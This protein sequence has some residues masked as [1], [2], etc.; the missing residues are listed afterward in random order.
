M[1]KYNDG[2]TRLMFRCVCLSERIN[3][4]HIG[5]I[6]VENADQKKKKEEKNTEEKT[7]AE[8]QGYVQVADTRLYQRICDFKHIA[9]HKQATSSVRW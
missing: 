8:K 9:L 3:Y 2:S 5:H 1:N 7:R 4:I 6:H